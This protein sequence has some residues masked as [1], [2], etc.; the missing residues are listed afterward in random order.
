ML[1]DSLFHR[2]FP[3]SDGSLPVAAPDFAHSVLATTFYLQF[4]LTGF[5]IPANVIPIWWQWLSDLNMLKYALQFLAITEYKDQIWTCSSSDTLVQISAA[6]A[7]PYERCGLGNTIQTFPGS[8]ADTVLKC[9]YACGYDLLDSYGVK[10]SVT[11]QV[12]SFAILHCF[13][14]FFAVCSY[15]ALRF[16]NHV[17]R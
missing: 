12:Q 8:S 13:A 1:L 5:F 10:Y 14:I 6:D 9:E 3:D 2:H 7:S 17:K 15:A 16:I 4:A 11:W